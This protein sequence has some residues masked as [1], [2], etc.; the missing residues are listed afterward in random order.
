MNRFSKTI[1]EKIVKSLHSKKKNDDDTEGRIRGK[2]MEMDTLN[3]NEMCV[4]LYQNQKI[5][6]IHLEWMQIP[7]NALTT[8]D[9]ILGS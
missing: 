5:Y 7:L 1:S 2:W 9:F 8:R 6:L 3:M 4:K